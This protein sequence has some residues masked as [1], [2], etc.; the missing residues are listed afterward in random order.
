V[1][2]LRA[3]IV[4]RLDKARRKLSTARKLLEQN[5]LEDAAGRAYYAMYHAA[6]A[7]DGRMRATFI[8]AVEL[9]LRREGHL[10]SARFA[11]AQRSP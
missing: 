1:A 2:D 11:D 6:H 7:E 10:G 8:D 9:L 4:A 5:E 3:R